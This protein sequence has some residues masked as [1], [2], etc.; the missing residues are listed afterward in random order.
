MTFLDLIGS[1]MACSLLPSFSLRLATIASRSIR[2][3]CRRGMV[4]ARVDMLSSDRRDCPEKDQRI[5]STGKSPKASLAEF[6]AVWAYNPA[7]GRSKLA[8]SLTRMVVKGRPVA[9]ATGNYEQA[10]ARSGR[11]T[12]GR[13]AAG[14]AVGAAF[15]GPAAGAATGL[16]GKGQSVVAPAGTLFES[17][18]AHCDA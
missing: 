7:L 1:A 11:K 15:G 14:A 12:A 16:I 9:I 5:A 2:C 3:L 17:E 13:A 18:L 8:L 4:T 6:S 10:G